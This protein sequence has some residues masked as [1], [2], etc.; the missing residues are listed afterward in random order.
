[1]HLVGA[2]DAEPGAGHGTQQLVVAV[3]DQVVLTEAEEREVVVREPGQELAPLGDL[4]VRQR[5]R[6]GLEV[7]DDRLHGGVHPP[8]VLDRFTDVLE[9]LEQGL[10]DILGLVLGHAVDLDVHPRLAVDVV[11]VGGRRVVQH[12]A[13]LAVEAPSY[14]ELGVHDLVHDVAGGVER[15]ADGVDQERHVVGD[16]L[17]HRAAT[18]GPAVVVLGRREQPHVGGALR[19]VPGQ[20]EM[21]QHGRPEVALVAVE[22]VLR[23][24]VAVVAADQRLEVDPRHR[25]Q[26]LGVRQNLLEDG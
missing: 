22:Q 8:P 13:Q 19:P 23:G 24:D 2:Q 9:H 17:D 21:V 16:H 3:L 12:L 5:R 26:L 4:V 11:G 14:D 20:V 1:M 7:G 6:V 25:R 15:H 18:A 10:P